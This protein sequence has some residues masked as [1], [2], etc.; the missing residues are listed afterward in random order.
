MALEGDELA[1]F[2]ERHLAGLQTA[3][4]AYRAGTRG[5]ASRIAPARQAPC[6]GLRPSGARAMNGNAMMAEANHEC[7]PDHPQSKCRDV[8]RQAQATEPELFAWVSANAGSGKT[9]VLVRRIQRLLLSGVEPPQILCL[10]YTE[11]A[12]AN[13]KNRLL[14]E[15]SAWVGKTDA[16]LD[17]HLAP[18]LRPPV[19]PADLRRAR[20]LFAVALQSRAGSRSARSTASARAFSRSRHSRRMCRRISRCWTK[21]LRHC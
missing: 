12:A 18:L 13:M 16:E 4:A 14:G 5:F 9:T 2:A 11:A 19:T 20:E 15:L 10:T 3:L 6:R 1:G 21:P 8:A 7:A 17:A